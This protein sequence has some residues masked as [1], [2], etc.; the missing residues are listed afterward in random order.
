MIIGDGDVAGVLKDRSGFCFFASGVSNSKE[1]DE[2][3]YKREMDL[4]L[5]QNDNFHLVYFSSLGIF[6]GTSRY[7]LHKMEMEETVKRFFPEY[8][9]VRLGNITWG[10]NPHTII[11][12]FKE[13]IKKGEKFDIKDEYRYLVT[14][15]EF[16]YWIDLIPEWSCEM[17]ITG[18]RIKVK[19]IVERI[20]KGLL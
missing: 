15:D 16:L 7:Y 4:L 13:K 20:K 18:E 14:K 5:L 17:N 12:F 9:I 6:D 11:N 3:E 8:T 1:T 10:K 2:A 19:E